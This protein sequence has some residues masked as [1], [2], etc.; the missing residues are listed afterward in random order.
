MHKENIKR[1]MN[2]LVSIYAHNGHIKREH[3]KCANTFGFGGGSNTEMRRS[4]ERPLKCHKRAQFHK[5]VRMQTEHNSRE[6]INTR[7]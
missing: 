2:R 6:N 5:K 3:M 4:G 1:K 7:C